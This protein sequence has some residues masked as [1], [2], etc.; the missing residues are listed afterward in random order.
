MANKVKNS[1]NSSTR[2]IIL[3]CGYVSTRNLPHYT[4]YTTPLTDLF[5]SPTNKSDSAVDEHFAIS[6]FRKSG[7]N[8]DLAQNSILLDNAVRNNTKQTTVQ[9]IV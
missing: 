6:M 8:N 1:Y 2:H 7:N 5:H 3:F 9:K 4:F